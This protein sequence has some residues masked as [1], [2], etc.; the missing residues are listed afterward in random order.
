MA[1]DHENSI[2]EQ[3]GKAEKFIIENKNSLAIIV[4]SAFIL[5]IIYFSYQR[6][7]LAPR[8]VEAIN[9]MYV[10][11][12]YFEND[13]LNKAINGDGSFMGF[14]SIIDEYSGTKAAN[15]AN[16][17]LGM[18]Y[19]KKGAFEKA[20]ESLENYSGNDELI[21]PLA[22]GAVADAQ[23][24]LGLYADAAKQYKAA[25]KKGNNKLIAP[26]FLMKMGLTYEQLKDNEKALKAYQEIKEKYSESAEAQ[27]VDKY[28]GRV[29]AKLSLN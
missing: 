24:E 19:L 29:E 21:A 10:A 1:K 16:Y 26:L 6:F 22:M 27:K 15:L 8:E 2:E 11:E 3:L 13:S 18:C 7:Y 5:F 23:S 9:Q 4:G 20:I 28:I 25:A 14:E 17:Y 12:K